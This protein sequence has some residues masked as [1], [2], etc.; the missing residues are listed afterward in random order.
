MLKVNGR[1]EVRVNEPSP[2]TSACLNA[3]E[4]PPRLQ[5]APIVIDWVLGGWSDKKMLR[6][7][8]NGGF[9]MFCGAGQIFLLSE[10]L[11]K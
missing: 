5:N 1:R 2:A 11:I 6:G 7:V 8:T 4:Y 3:H 9:S 10:L